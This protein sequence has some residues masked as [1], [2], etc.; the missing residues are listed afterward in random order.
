MPYPNPV[1]TAL[2]APT[3]GNTTGVRPASPVGGTWPVPNQITTSDLVGPPA[4]NRQEVDLWSRTELVKTAVNSL[5]ANSTYLAGLFDGNGWFLPPAGV[6]L[7]P[8]TNAATENFVGTAISTAVG[9]LAG[10]DSLSPRVIADGTITGITTIA[11]VLGSFGKWYS[12]SASADY[13]ITLPDPATF[14]GKFIGFRCDGTFTQDYH[15]VSIKPAGVDYFPARAVSQPIVLLRGNTLVLMANGANK[16]V[17][18]SSRLD[19]NW[20]DAAAALV[21]TGSTSDPTKGTIAYDTFFWRRQGNDLLLYWAFKQTSVGTPGDGIYLWTI[22]FSWAMDLTY[23]KASAT[24]TRPAAGGSLI[25]GFRSELPTAS[26]IGHVGVYN[27][28]KVRASIVWNANDGPVSA[29]YGHFNVVG[30]WSF[31]ITVPITHW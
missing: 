21:V 18:V 8:G 22:P 23:L 6:G 10:Y 16:W 24:D 29:T 25:G 31:S 26:Q 11:T 4:A 19:T 7:S 15:Q 9:G 3:A 30:E 13:V 1:I 28:N 27:A 5:I 12:I 17:I 2:G 14:A 20:V